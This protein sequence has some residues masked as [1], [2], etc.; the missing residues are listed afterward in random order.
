MLYNI[1]IIIYIFYKIYKHSTT[2]ELANSPSHLWYKALNTRYVWV[3]HQNLSIYMHIIQ[4]FNFNTTPYGRSNKF[5]VTME[6]VFIKWYKTHQDMK[7]DFQDYNP[8]NLQIK[9]WET[10]SHT[11]IY[12]F[13][14]S[15]ILTIIQLVILTGWYKL[16]FEL[17]CFWNLSPII[18]LVK[19]IASNNL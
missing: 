16:L 10:A 18:S 15:V 11:N 4:N 5:W 6:I 9:Q 7:F 8:C 13:P 14:I 3:T 17:K 12:W 1:Y 19:F 2:Q